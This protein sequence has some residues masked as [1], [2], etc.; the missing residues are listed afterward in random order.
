MQLKDTFY[1]QLE[2]IFMS[3]IHRV[4]CK[5]CKKNYEQIELYTHSIRNPDVPILKTYVGL[6]YTGNLIQRP[7]L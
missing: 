7:K 3:S 2:N 5:E 6:Y 1:L 4:V